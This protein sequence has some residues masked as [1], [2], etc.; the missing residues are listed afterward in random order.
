MTNPPQA[1]Q[2]PDPPAFVTNNIT[3]V[4]QRLVQ[5]Y[6]TTGQLRC[7]FWSLDIEI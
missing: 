3:T 1:D 5:R 2:T 7:M 4:G 6:G